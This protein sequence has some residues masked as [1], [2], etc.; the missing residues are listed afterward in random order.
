MKISDA[1]N[2]ISEKVQKEIMDN[3][4]SNGNI[5]IEINYSQGAVNDVKIMPKR[6]YTKSKNEE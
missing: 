6:I 1:C 5:Q 3:I 4:R 2:L